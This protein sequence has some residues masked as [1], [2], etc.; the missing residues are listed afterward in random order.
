VGVQQDQTSFQTWAWLKNEHSAF[1]G[2]SVVASML[3]K[4]KPPSPEMD[5]ALEHASLDGGAANAETAS[6]G[7]TRR[8]ELCMVDPGPTIVSPSAFGSKR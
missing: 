8:V 2:P 3:V 6:K 1:T 7:M 5:S 4:A